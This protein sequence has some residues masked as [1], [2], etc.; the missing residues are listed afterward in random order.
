[1]ALAAASADRSGFERFAFK[2]GGGFRFDRPRSAAVFAGLGQ[3]K[4]DGERPSGAGRELHFPGEDL[5]RKVVDPA[6]LA[7]ERAIERQ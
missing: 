7:Q 2:A 3:D 6:E 1:M 5:E 4:A